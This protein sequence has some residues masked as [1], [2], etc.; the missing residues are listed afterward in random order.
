MAAVVR[1]REGD[2]AYILLLDCLCRDFE[3][4]AGTEHAFVAGE[5][6]DGGG[7]VAIEGEKRVV[8]CDRRLRVD[9]IA[10]FRPRQDDGPDRAGFFYCDGHGSNDSP[11]RRV[12]TSRSSTHP[13]TPDRRL[14]RRGFGC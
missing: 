13:S 8:E 9:G 6:G 11:G 10:R 5:H 12:F 1:L 3:I 4:E 7:F 14:T 2:V